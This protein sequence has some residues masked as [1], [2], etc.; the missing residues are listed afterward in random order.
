LSC[1]YPF[2]GKL[3]LS[4]RGFIRDNAEF[5]K[6]PYIGNMVLKEWSIEY[7]KSE[8]RILTTTNKRLERF[9]LISALWFPDGRIFSF[10]EELA[11]QIIKLA[12]STVISVHSGH[13]RWECL[14]EKKEHQKMME[15][16]T[17]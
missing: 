4:L 9:D 13:A 5:E 1:N 6:Y 15:S 2:Q 7:P 16:I 12:K 14:T 3:P 8:S 17:S 10:N 11:E